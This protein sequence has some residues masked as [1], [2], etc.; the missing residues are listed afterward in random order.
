MIPA[1]D[2]EGDYKA[3][4]KRGYDACARAYD[5]S[6]ITEPGTEIR[7]LSDRLQ[8]G[9]A[10]LDVGCGAGVPVSRWLA[11]RCRVT[12]VDVSQEM[13]H[14]ARR[15]VPTGDFLCADIMSVR[16]PPDSFH[17]VVAF[18]SVFHLPREEHPDLFRRI[19][20]WLRPGGHMLCTLSYCN[21]EGYTE[22]D[23]FGATMYWSNYSLEEYLE[24]LNEV[25]FVL[26]EVGST[27]DGYEELPQDEI[28]DHALVL[29]RKP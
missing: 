17:A 25:G 8:D 29:A 11:A 20:R 10:V 16:Y 19:H 15:N 21:E 14:L 24:I 1:I 23:F 27:A 7:G 5:G 4:V 12:G 6:R 26:L 3:L 18:Y 2:P 28:E 9:D 13:V 22:E